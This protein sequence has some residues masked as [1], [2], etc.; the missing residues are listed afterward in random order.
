MWLDVMNGRL[1][2][3]E[4]L[5]RRSGNLSMPEEDAYRAR[6]ILLPLDASTLAGMRYV[7]HAPLSRIFA[8]SL[9]ED[10]LQSFDKVSEIYLLNH[11]ER[12]FDALEFYRSVSQPVNEGNQK[13][14]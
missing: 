10:S 3:S 2:C 13:S 8:F 7:Y 4:C 5:R 6:N 1:I 12:S 9:T 11:L 14:L